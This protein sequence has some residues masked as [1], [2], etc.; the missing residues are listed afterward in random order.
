MELFRDIT[1]RGIFAR[2]SSASCGAE[3][4][5]VEGELYRDLRGEMK[6]TNTQSYSQ[7]HNLL[8]FDPVSYSATVEDEEQ[9]KSR[10]LNK[11]IKLGDKA[12]L[13]AFIYRH[14]QSPSWSKAVQESSGRSSS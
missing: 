1:C 8:P 10:I 2:N 13:F 14:L 3:E 5:R 7:T 11:M 4:W 6:K 12:T 9:Q